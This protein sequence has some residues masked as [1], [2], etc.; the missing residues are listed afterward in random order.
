MFV[1]L[2]IL[3]ANRLNTYLSVRL[4]SILNASQLSGC[5]SCSLLSQDRQDSVQLLFFHFERESAKY[6]SICAAAFHFE[7]SEWLL[8]LF[9][10]VARL[11]RFCSVTF[12]FHFECESAE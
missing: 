7:V 4:L 12:F 10:S 8:V 3:K 6:L 5:S 11:A 2:S 9:P 1:L